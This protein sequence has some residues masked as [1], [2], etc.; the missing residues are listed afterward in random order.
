VK[1]IKFTF[2]ERKAVQAAARFISRG[3]GEMNYLA[4]MKLLYLADREALLRYGRPITGDKVV[5]MK[6]GP[7]LSRVYN[8]VSHKKQE[9]PA[10]QW[11]KF[12]A[13]PDSYV[14]TVRFS[15]V[16]DISELSQAE[17]AL[18]DEIFARFQG[19]DEWSLVAYTHTLPEWHDPK[20][21]S[22][23]IPFEDILKAAKK[24]AEEIK[25]IAEDA[26]ADSF[27]ESALA[28]VR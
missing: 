8:L 7:V 21:T 16:P 24:P 2:N 15:G 13:R 12:I 18:I 27:M 17:V 5:A 20:N 10:S 1:P 23:P 19:W 28:K 26:E 4:L 9:L 14:Y 22:V 11:H 6:H 25:A 3:G